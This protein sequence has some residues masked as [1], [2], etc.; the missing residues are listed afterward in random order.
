ML[1][2]T[3]KKIDEIEGREHST[4]WIDMM[5][6]LDQKMKPRKRWTKTS[7][8]NVDLLNAEDKEY[9]LQLLV[10]LGK[11]LLK[12]INM[13]EDYSNEVDL[14]D[15]DNDPESLE[16]CST[17]IWESKDF[18][19][20]QF[21]KLVDEF[22]DFRHEKLGSVDATDNDAWDTYQTKTLELYV[23]THSK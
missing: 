18:I 5:D 3:E 6:I 21:S 1:W 23:T 2:D 22:G 14:D 12:I 7:E 9:I 16:I 8:M 19:V 13:F 15:P 10:S 11:H 20:N 4:E 17:L